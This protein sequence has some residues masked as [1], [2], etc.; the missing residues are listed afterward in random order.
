MTVAHIDFETRSAVDLTKTGAYVYAADPTTDVWCAA[1]AIGDE[2][3]KVWTPGEPLPDDLAEHIMMGGVMVA[4]NAAFER[5]IF[6]Y[7]MGPR[8][9]WPMPDVTQWRC[10]M[11]MAYA[12]ALPGS[13]ENAA[14]AAGL[15][16]AKDM[17]GRRLMLQMAKPRKILNEKKLADARLN[18]ASLNGNASMNA[19]LKRGQY[20][21]ECDA[22]IQWWDEPAKLQKLIEYCKQDVEVERALEKRLR[23]LSESELALWHLDQIINDRGILVDQ[24]LCEAAKQVV[25]KAQ[26]A[27]DDKMFRLTNGTVSKCTN[28]NQIVKWVRDQGVQCDSINKASMETLLEEDSPIPPHVREVLELRRESAKASVAKIDALLNGRSPEDGRAKGL[29]QYHAASTGRWGG[30]RFQPQNIKRPNESDIDTAIE[31]VATGDYDYVTMMYEQPLSVVGDCLRGMVMAS[32]GHRIIAADY[33]NIEGRVLAWLAGEQWKLDAF[34]AYDAGAGHDLYKIA[35]GKILGK[36]PGT[37]TK[38]ERQSPGKVSELA[39]G[40]QGGVGAFRTMGGAAVELMD[41]DE[42]NVIK[43]AW[44]DAHPNIRQFWFDM[45]DAAV[46]AVQS[47]GATTTCGKVKFKYAGSWLFMRLP[48]GRLLAYPYPE[49]REFDTPWGDPKEGLTYFSTIDPSKKAKVI[50]DDRN[51]TSWARIKTYGGM[52]VE[53]ATQAVARDIMADAMPRLEAAGYKILLTV[54]D[55]VVTEVPDDHGSVEEME[56]IMSTLPEWA[57]GCP[58]AA[59]GFEAK[60]YRK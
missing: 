17:A 51:G 19:V 23:P 9:G 2:P 55:E 37:V 33:S 42:I 16:I 36:D 24:S 45:E 25:A 20:K 40:Y 60:R 56:T 57:A 12:L 7:I 39:L 18:M 59:E 31:I 3:V 27:L 29:L 28:R 1:Y 44:R 48:S 49:V 35:A 21:S 8:Y 4:H 11:A 46:R 47:K 50:D 54:H 14:P 58:V 38:D 5:I 13:L 15:D 26:V 52:L 43:D 22:V 41:D 6:H 10:T 30:R 32:E 34:R 53:N